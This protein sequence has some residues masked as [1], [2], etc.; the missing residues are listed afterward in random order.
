M[1]ASAATRRRGSSRKG[2]VYDKTAAQ[3]AVDFFRQILHHTKAEW[4]GRPFVLAPWQRKEVIEPLFGWKR[5]DG[6]R[7]YRT[8][9]V[10]VPRKNGKSTLAAGVALYLTF[11]DGEA[12]AEVY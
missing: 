5:P 9:Y 4:S 11:A 8:V 12:G 7:K 10:E 3:R 1:T 6:T 2:F